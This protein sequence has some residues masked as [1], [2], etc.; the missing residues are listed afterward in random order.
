MQS[1]TV[2]EFQ[3]TGNTQTS[4][5][6]IRHTRAPGFRRVVFRHEPREVPKALLMLVVAPLMVTVSLIAT[7]IRGDTNAL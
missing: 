4:S 6:M 3:K 5:S 7:L 2:D 1:V